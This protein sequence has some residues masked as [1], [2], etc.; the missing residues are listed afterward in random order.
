MPTY[1]LI[2]CALIF[3]FALLVLWWDYERNL[4]E[5]R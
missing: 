5:K 1:I 4:H 3:I 2:R